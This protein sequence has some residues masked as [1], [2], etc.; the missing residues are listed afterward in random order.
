MSAKDYERGRKINEETELK[1]GENPVAD[2]IEKGTRFE[3]DMD[4][5]KE[6]EDAINS[7]NREDSIAMRSVMMHYRWP[8]EGDNVYI[9]Y[10]I[11]GPYNVNETAHI[12]RAF[13]DYENNTC[14]R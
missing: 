10:H 12:E 2:A 4:L 8:R 3:G 7:G 5:T 14:I 13:M 11:T 9:P 6:E 1:D